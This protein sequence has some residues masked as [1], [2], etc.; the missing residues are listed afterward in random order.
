[1]ATT[2]HIAKLG[3]IVLPH[4]PYSPDLA[5]SDFHLFGPGQHFPDND[6]V[7]AAVRKWLA[8]AGSNFYERS[9][10]AL[11]HRWQKC[12]TNGGDYVKK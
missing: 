11:V 6:A 8:S 12:L 4:P 1:L 7:I 2:A 3:W 10:Q 5:S 9:I